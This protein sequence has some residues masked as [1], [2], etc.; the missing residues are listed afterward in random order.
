VRA[1]GQPLVWHDALCPGTPPAFLAECVRRSV[2]RDAV[3]AGV[4]AVT[5]TVKELVETPEGPTV[6]RTLDRDALRHLASPLVLPAGVVD[7]LADWPA[8][9][10]P[11]ALAQLRAGHPVELVAAPPSSARVHDATDLAR[12]EALTAP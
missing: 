2:E 9:D 1:S 12:I 5:D 4:L 10:F 7:G 6:G 11:T 8:A 3:V